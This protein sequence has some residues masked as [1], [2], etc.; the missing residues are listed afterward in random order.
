MRSNGMKMRV[1]WAGAITFTFTVAVTVTVTVLCQYCGR[2][3]GR[4]ETASCPDTKQVRCGAVR[5]RTPCPSRVPR[6]LSQGRSR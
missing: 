5:V 3:C 1:R 2:C 6:F 4:H